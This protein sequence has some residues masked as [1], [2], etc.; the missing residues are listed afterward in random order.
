M[1][2]LPEVETTRRGIATIM[3]GQ[4]LKE[5]IVHEPRMR[6]P[7]PDE[8]PSWVNNQVILACER[9]GKYLLLR[10]AHGTQLIH[11]G[12]SGS[13]RRVSMDAPRLKHDHVEWIFKNARFLLNDPRRFG[14][15]L[16]HANEQGPLLEHPLLS[17]LGVEPF[18]DD[19]TAEHLYQGL[20][21]RRIAVKPALLSGAIVVG[22]GNIYASESLF[23]AGI[24]PTV[25]ANS[26]SPARVKR[27]HQ[28]IVIT[29][30]QAL[31]AGGSSLRDYVTA[32]G[33]PGAYFELHALVYDKLGQPCPKCQRPIKRIVQNQRAT[34]FC[35][36]CQ[37]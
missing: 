7:I 21:K 20:Q 19:F 13:L 30:E 31:E 24:D 22:V 29:L 16:W 10:F 18:S 9:R 6:W 1:P 8:L 17:R 26:I 3:K 14:S 11:L 5:F 2:E 34:Y 37:R 25:P 4:T 36:S 27:L 35:S 15:V 12:M 23:R 32:T 33:E 28:A